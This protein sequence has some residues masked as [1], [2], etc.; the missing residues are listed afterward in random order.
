MFECV[1]LGDSIAVGVGQLS[2]ECHTAAQVGISSRHFLQQHTVIP[3]GNRTLISLGSNDGG[4]TFAQIYSSL[5]EVRLRIRQ[6]EVTW[7]QSSNNERAGIAAGRLA[8]EF[9]DR[10]I[11][12]RPYVSSDG[13]HPH[14]RGYQAIA[15]QFRGS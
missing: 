9:G 14:G 1:I 12:V 4:Q 15:R 7:L 3:Q 2:Q 13:V 6:G 5:R 11:E 10:V 8:R